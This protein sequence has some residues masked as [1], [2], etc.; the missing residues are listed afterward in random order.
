MI[1]VGVIGYGYWGPNIVRNFM[2]NS[3]TKVV[4]V[5]D[6]NQERLDRVQSLYPSVSVTLIYIH[7]NS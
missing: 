1:N 2:V 3:E 4:T 6:S 5:C 7:N